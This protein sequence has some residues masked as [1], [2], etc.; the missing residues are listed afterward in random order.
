MRKKC[1]ECTA[2]KEYL[3]WF[4][5]GG[6][7]KTA[8]SQTISIFRVPKKPHAYGGTCH[9]SQLYLAGSREMAI[10]VYDM[11]GTN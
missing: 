6:K 8:G 7:P 2:L 4:C 11:K 9:L 1:V 5:R 10:D 3:S